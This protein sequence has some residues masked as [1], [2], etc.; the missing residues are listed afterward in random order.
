MTKAGGR[1]FSQFGIAELENIVT[2]N[3]GDR[4]VLE[5]VRHEL[6]F[7]STQ[8]A[9]RLR[10]RLQQMLRETLEVPD[11][12]KSG[13]QRQTSLSRGEAP[14]SPEFAFEPEPCRQASENSPPPRPLPGRPVSNDADNRMEDILRA[15][16]V[17]EVLSPATFK[18]A[19]DLAGGDSRRIAHLD[20]ALPWENAPAKGPMGTRVYFQ[21]VLGTI[22]MEPAMDRLLA[23]FADKRPE[24]PQARGET[25]LAIVIVDRF[26]KPVPDACATVSSFAWGFPQALRADPASLAAWT[27]QEEL[28]QKELHSRPYREDE[29]EGVRPLTLQAL[30]AAFEW[31]VQKCGLDRV[32]VRRPSFMVRSPVSVKS[33]EPPEPVLLNSFYLKDLARAGELVRTGKCPETLQRFLGAKAPAARKDL[34]N[35]MEAVEAALAP[36][37]FPPAR[38]PGAGRH[39]LVL[40]Q[41]AAVNLA[42]EQGPGEVLAVNGPPGTGKT[43]LLRDVVASLVTQRADAMARFDD[44]ETAFTPSGQKLNFGSAFVHLYRVDQSLKGFE[45][46]IASSNNKAVENVSA[47]LPAIGAVA[48]DAASLRYFEPLA[49]EL[50]GTKAWGAIAAVLG[51]AGNRSAF[52]DRFWWNKETGLFGYLK[53]VC[54][55]PVEIDLP[56][57]TTRPPRIVSELQPPTDRRDA[58]RRWH[59]ARARYIE[60]RGR[61][62]AQLKAAEAL[63]VASLHLP[64]FRGAF[65]ACR[66]HASTRPGLISRLFGTAAWRH[67]KAEHLG[68]STGFA[69]AGRALAGTTTLP[70]PAGDLASS[71]W[72]RWRPLPAVEAISNALTSALAALRDQ[73]ALRGAPVLDDAFFD[74][75]RETI[76]TA[77]PWL[78]AAEHRDRDALF[79]A[80][81]G[82]HRAFIDAAAKP[83]RQNLGVAMQ[84]LDGKGLDA[85]EKD[86][87]IPDIWSS[88][89][90]VVPAVSTTFAS[91]AVML[92][93]VPPASL[94][95]LLVDEAGQA[96]PQQAVG[97]LMRVQRAIVVGDPVQVEPVVLLPESLTGAICRSFGVDP[98]RFAAPAGSVQTLADEATSS[99]A[100]FPARSGTRTVGVPLLVHRRCANPMFKIANRVAYEGLMVQAKAAKSSPV[101]ELLGPARWIDT[102]GSGEDKWCEAEGLAAVRMLEDMVRAGV[103]L[104]LYIVTPFVI[105]ADGLRRMIAES[106]LLAEAIPDIAAWARSRVG[107]VHTVQG[108]EAEAVLFVLGAPDAGQTSARGWAGKAPNLLN[109]AMTRAKEV[110]YVIGNRELWKRAGVFSDLDALLE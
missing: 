87:L 51:N 70:L 74:E 78:T 42:S 90:L 59:A 36:A 8:R 11:A 14:G 65:E 7:R 97:A 15:W 26:G 32:D 88:L 1:P 64:R 37:R 95:W 93:M 39:P 58:M 76:Q 45:M 38:W 20:R 63:R 104:D 4:G 46:L 107:T 82:L 100:E 108:R 79:E 61:V 30:D 85:P 27:T 55:T 33:K 92:K 71:P 101:R 57:G 41:Q 98:D 66:E 2:K 94:G 50:L 21:I 19:A 77:A 109:V 52:R 69:K 40:M 60:V 84:V 56:D 34:L 106:A 62:E 24:R 29:R 22:K 110:A 73:Q 44:P 16:T 86:S 10:M 80:A 105:V 49:D 75:K 9:D 3:A 23:R 102:R 12:V 81:L 48:E 18:R 17:L 54:G 31:L 47:E 83:L 89:F 53:T 28:I 68:L 35:D 91:V 25:P 6:G 13:P 72:L 103:E 96:S 43:T 5:T 67:W 99:F